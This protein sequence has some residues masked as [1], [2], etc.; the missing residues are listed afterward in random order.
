MD[1]KSLR[2]FIAAVDTGSITAAGE[3][4]HVAQP[5]ITLAVTKLE[6]ELGVLLLNRGRTGVTPTGAGTELYH[7]ARRLLADSEA[8]VQKFRQQVPLP[9]LSIQLGI[10]LS[11]ERMRAVMQR[12]KPWQQTYQIELVEAAPDSPVHICLKEHVPP[13][14]HYEPLWRDEYCVLLPSTHPV[15]LQSKI[16]LQDLHPLGLIERSFCEYSAVWQQFV[17]TLPTPPC[18]VAHCASE[19]WAWVM[20]ESGLGVCIGP[21]P[22]EAEQYQIKSIPLSNIPSLPP[23][24]R[25]IGIAISPAWLGRLHAQA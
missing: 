24:H 22:E 17:E 25:E 21:A 8:L 9:P 5:S 3:A 19:E 20:V 13:N 11:V 2:Y 15:A 6:A 23:V 12:F 10:T 14:Y 7:H 4:C 16:R 1:L 18:I